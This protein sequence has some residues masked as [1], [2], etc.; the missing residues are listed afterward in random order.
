MPW[1][2]V[3]VNGEYCVYKLDADGN[4]EGEPLGCH[5][6]EAEA[7]AQL[8]A[9]YANVDD[10]QKAIP[11]RNG[12]DAGGYCWLARIPASDERLLAIRASV[13]GGLD[14][15]GMRPIELDD[16]HLTLVC[17]EDA[18]PES[19]DAPRIGEAFSVVVDAVDQFETP[20]GYAIHLRIRPDGDLMALQARLAA[21]MSA[22]GMALA[23]PYSEPASYVPHI[24]LAYS[25][26]P[27]TPFAVEPFAIVVRQV[28]LCGP[29]EREVIAHDLKRQ[30]PAIH[31]KATPAKQSAPRQG[32][33]GIARRGI[34]EY[35]AGPLMAQDVEDRTVTGIAAVLGNVDAGGD[36]LLPGAFAKTLRENR[37]RV[38]HLWNHDVDEPPTAAIRD[39]R[40][41]DA[42][43]LPSDLREQ[44]PDVV[45]GLQVTREYLRTPRAEEVLEGIKSGAITEMSFGYQTIKGRFDYERVGGQQVRNLRE[46][47]LF[48]T[49]DV[50]FGMN[51]ATRAMKGLSD[52][53]LRDLLHS[54]D[55]LRLLRAGQQVSSDDL[56]AYERVLKALEDMLA[57][58]V[59]AESDLAE[60]D[61]T[62]TQDAAPAPSFLMASAAVRPGMRQ[63]LGKAL[64]LRLAIAEREIMKWT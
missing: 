10:A 53:V 52:D 23:S 64:L 11:A 50:L 57:A 35:K 24:T 42:R 29:D 6:T 25:P 5:A 19:Y 1:Q 4:P 16:L 26:T 60:Q 55:V 36:R 56:A 45:G 46:V 49:S 48:E 21:S 34:V 9:L 38:R 39:I 44:F 30:A 8:H 40:E 37:E 58:P 32:V 14:D 41:V 15:E 22:V 59:A 43:A 61:D 31:R 20:D 7:D 62:P 33:Q 54:Q 51:A 63:P 47:R 27:I 17:S 2:V 12:S 13:L 18:L 3:E 28:A